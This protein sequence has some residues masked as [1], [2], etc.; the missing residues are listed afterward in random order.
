MISA[1]TLEACS[2]LIASRVTRILLTLTEN[3]DLVVL[4]IRAASATALRSERIGARSRGE[5]PFGSYPRRR[6]LVCYAVLVRNG[7]SISI[8]WVSI[9]KEELLVGPF[10]DSTLVAQ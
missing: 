2:A 5:R 1:T 3:S 6:R 4:G 9:A 10:V 8:L 7:K